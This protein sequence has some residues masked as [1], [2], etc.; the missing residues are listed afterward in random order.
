MGVDDV[1]DGVEDGAACKDEEVLLGDVY[2]V[3]VLKGGEYE[4]EPD[5]SDFQSSS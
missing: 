4:D 2:E 5:D 3:D 1:I